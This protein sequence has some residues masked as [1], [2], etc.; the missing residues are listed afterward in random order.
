MIRITSTPATILGTA[1][2][3]VAMFVAPG[4]PARA[5]NHFM[6]IEQV[7][8]GVDGDTSAQAVQLRTRLAGQNFTAGTRLVVWDAAGAHPVV[9]ENLTQNVAIGAAGSRVL[10]AT[11]NFSSAT[12]PAAVPN[13]VLDAPIPDSYLAAG[14]MTFE[15][16]VTAVIFWRLSWG[17][18]GYTGSTT[19]SATN[20]V[21]GQFAPNFP[22]PLPSSSAIA[23]RFIGA[24]GALST[25]NAANY[26]LTSGPAVFTNNAGTNFVVQTAT[27][28]PVISAGAE[29]LIRDLRVMPNPFR[30]ATTL[31]MQLARRADAK[32][33]VVDTSGRRVHE[34]SRTL[35][36]GHAAV[37]WDGRNAEGSSLPAGV[38]FYRLEIENDV[39]RGR[40]I[41]IR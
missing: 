19:G 2:A 12:S 4:T 1:L 24:A 23:V 32:L 15:D 8:G 17:G 36:A 6:Q 9:I 18:T 41:L 31:E 28:A 16:A 22:D 34:W 21:D 35:P 3:A 33:V 39:R 13:F 7:I 27:D 30:T 11:P 25:N 14:S 37:S 38:Y 40:L 10:L 29:H 26:A 5:E 20:D